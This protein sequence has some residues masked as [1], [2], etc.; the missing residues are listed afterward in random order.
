MTLKNSLTKLSSQLKSDIKAL[1][2]YQKH[3]DLTSYVILAVSKTGKDYYVAYNY[4]DSQHTLLSRMSLFL[5]ERQMY[6]LINEQ[7]N[8]RKIEA[9]MN[10]EFN[11]KTSKLQ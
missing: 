5:H 2:E 11:P 10:R 9:E 6:F 3:S 8:E 7:E 4:E 1:E